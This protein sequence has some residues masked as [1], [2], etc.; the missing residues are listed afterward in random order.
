[1]ARRSRDAQPEPM[2][3]GYPQAPQEGYPQ[4]GYL[5]QGY[6]QQG[7]PQAPQGYAQP[8]LPAGYVLKKKKPIYKRVWV[9]LLLIIVVIII[10]VVASAGKAVNDAVN[11][12]HTVVYNVTGKGTA[13]ISY[14][15]SDGSGKDVSIT[16][17]NQKLPWTKT[18]TVKGDLSGFVVTATVS[19][20][21]KTISNMSCELSVD[22]KVVSTDKGN[23]SIVSCS[24]SGYSG[25]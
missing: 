4:Q 5:Q 25:K 15:Q 9:W 2:Q 23:N 6:L 20:F 10:A 3:Q 7:Y 17:N 11:K 19:D 21:T 18:V 16:E 8:P 12:Q 13:D 22:G 14:Y 24:G 1:M